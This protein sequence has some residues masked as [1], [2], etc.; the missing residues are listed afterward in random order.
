MT[1]SSDSPSSPSAAHDIAPVGRL[2]SGIPGLDAI[3]GG[4]FFRRSF[5]HHLLAAA[6][7]LGLLCRGCFFDCGN[8][9][10]SRGLF[11]NRGGHFG[12][13]TLLGNDADI[14]LFLL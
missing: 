12:F 1:A 7:R 6:A 13:F 9:L 3:L 4:G 2:T 11:R 5:G 8:C 14:R 10:S